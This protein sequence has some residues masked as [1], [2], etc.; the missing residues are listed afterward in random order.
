MIKQYS[1]KEKSPNKNKIF[2]YIYCRSRSFKLVFVNS[3]TIKMKK[4]AGLITIT[5]TLLLQS[6][7]N[8]QTELPTGQ[9][10]AEIAGVGMSEP[11]FFVLG[12]GIGASARMGKYF[13]LNGNLSYG[14]RDFP[15]SG[16]TMKRGITYLSLSTDFYPAKA[17]RGFYIGP[18]LSYMQVNKTAKDGLPLAALESEPDTNIGLGLQIGFNAK[19]SRSIHLI[20]RA[21]AGLSNSAMYTGTVGVGYTIWE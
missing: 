16:G 18:F 13:S 12:G 15:L 14:Q 4:L 2:S 11:G 21:S 1:Q 3:N 7:M 20:T 19:M 9:L 5:C 8:A 6:V 10:R 17:F